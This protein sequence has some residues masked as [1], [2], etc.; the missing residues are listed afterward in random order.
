MMI[1]LADIVL[2]LHAGYAAFVIA[3]LLAVPIGGWLDWRWVRTR[4]LRIAHV[5]CTA[6]VA[7][8]ALI[9]M[10]CPLTWLEHILLVASGAPGYERTFIAHL[11]YRLLYYEAP[12]WVFTVAYTLVALTVLL[13]YRY[14]P[15]LPR[16]SRQQS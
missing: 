16:L 15:P 7:V 14:V 11:L 6:I 12:A 3:G 5:L 2:L 1:L 4:C 10:I 9:G 8:E 13:L